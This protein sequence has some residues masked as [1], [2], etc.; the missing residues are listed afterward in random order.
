MSVSLARAIKHSPGHSAKI[1]PLQRPRKMSLM[2]KVLLAAAAVMSLGIAVLAHAAQVGDGSQVGAFAVAQPVAT[3][4]AVVEQPSHESQITLGSAADQERVIAMAFPANP[5]GIV[6]A[7]TAPESLPS[8]APSVDAGATATVFLRA[9][10]SHSYSLA[11]A[12]ALMLL[13]WAAGKF[14][15][16][17]SLPPKY[18]PWVS[19]AISVIGAACTAIIGH[20]ALPQAFGAGFEA[21]LAAVGAWEAAGQHFL[22][23]GSAPKA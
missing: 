9:F 15:L 22:S 14:G 8:T 16:L 13:V 5:A 18:V 1:I 6:T 20:K 2:A 23:F 7:Q 4:H 3:V 17:G 10:Q 12:A 19:V 11:I 21:G